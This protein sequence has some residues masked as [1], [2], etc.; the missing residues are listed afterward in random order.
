MSTTQATLQNSKTVTVKSLPSSFMRRSFV[1]VGLPRRHSLHC[2]LEAL[3]PEQLVLYIRPTSYS[4]RARTFKLPSQS[5]R[6]S[7]WGLGWPNCTNLTDLQPLIDYIVGM[8]ILLMDGDH[9][10]GLTVTVKP[11]CDP[12]RFYR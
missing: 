10:M 11:C 9:R 5:I 2:V 1:M 8:L 6:Y 7:Y 12:R 4:T 3:E